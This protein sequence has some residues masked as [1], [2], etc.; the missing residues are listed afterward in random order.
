MPRVQGLSYAEAK[1]VMSPRLNSYFVLEQQVETLASTQ[2]TG[3]DWPPLVEMYSFLE[4]MAHL[5]HRM[6]P[7]ENRVLASREF[8][9]EP[10]PGPFFEIGERLFFEYHCYEADD[11]SDALLWYHSCQYCTVLELHGRDE[12]ELYGPNYRIRFDD[13]FE[14]EANGDEMFRRRFKVSEF[15]AANKDRRWYPGEGCRPAETPKARAYRAK[16]NGI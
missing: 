7:I 8:D 5:R 12:E 1:S 4:K 11:S 10:Y 13:G 3:H 9:W 6:T 2:R 15:R 16:L 14:G